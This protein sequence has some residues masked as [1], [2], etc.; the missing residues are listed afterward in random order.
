MAALV[1]LLQVRL[2]IPGSRN[3]KDKRRVIKSIKD[4]LAHQ[5]NVSIA[6]VDDLDHRQKASLAIA[7]VSN[8]GRFTESCLSKI[9]DRLRVHPEASLVDYQIECL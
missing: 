3:L 9:V 1:G 5:H 2:A 7:M 6:E 4:R 8:N